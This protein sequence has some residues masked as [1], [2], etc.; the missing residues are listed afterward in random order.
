MREYFRLVKLLKPYRHLLVFSFILIIFFSFFNAASI[1]LSIP[2]LKTL[3][4][5]VNTDLT[6]IPNGNFF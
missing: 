2:L 4:T 3:F 5:G 6:V 1:Y